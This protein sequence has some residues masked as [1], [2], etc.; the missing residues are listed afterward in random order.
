MTRLILTLLAF[1]MLSGFSVQPM[2]ER[3]A[4]SSLPK[5]QNP[6]W[7]TLRKTKLHFNEKSG[8]L[9]AKFPDDVKAMEGKEITIS[10]FMMPLEATEKFKHFLLSKSTPTC[11]FCPPGEA[12]EIIDVVTDKAVTY[13]ENLVTVTGTFTLINNQEMGMFF[14]MSKA[15]L[16]E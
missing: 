4:Q 13:N 11:P 12:N 10:G 2:D 6:L 7:S 3:K 9:S 16:K 14:K 1:L 5:S 8:I 15:K